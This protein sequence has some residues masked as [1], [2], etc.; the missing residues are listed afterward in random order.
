MVRIVS[1]ILFAAAA[2]ASASGCCPCCRGFVR[3]PAPIVVQPPVQPPPVVIQPP[4][5]NQDMNNPFK[6][7]V[8]GPP[9]DKEYVYN[10][11]TGQLLLNNQVIGAGYS[12]KGAAKNN[13]AMQNTPKVGPIPA[14]EYRIAFRRN[15][16]KTN[17]PIIDLHPL[18][19]NVPGR[20]PGEFF[21]I[22]ADSNPPGNA[23]ESGIVMPRNV[24]EMIEIGAF[25][26]LKVV[27]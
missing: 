19:I 6:E 22:H 15:D 20:I 24:R 23:G 8:V 1:L 10:Q 13:P 16:F 7:K 14:G 26:K 21:N 5:P 4:P 12:G 18:G 9:A 11:R 25:T 3:L 17:E 2:C 27:Q